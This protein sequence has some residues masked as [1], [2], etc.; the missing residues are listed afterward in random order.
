MSLIEQA[1]VSAIS[2]HANTPII[3]AYSG[4]VDSQ[5]LLHALASLKKNQ[6]LTNPITVCHVNHGL[7]VNAFAWQEFAQQ[8]C[9]RLALPLI[10]KQVNVQAKAQS[11]LEALARDARYQALVEINSTSSLIITGH[12]SDDQ[13]ETF[14]LALKRG[15]GLKG[16]ASMLANSTLGKHKLI[17]PLLGV[18]RQAIVTYAQEQQLSWIEDE[19]NDDTSFDRNF[20]RQEVMPLLSARWGSISQTI[21]R[22]A[23]HCRAGQELLDELGEQ[24]LLHCQLSASVLNVASLQSLSIA[25]FN[26]LIRYFLAK[27][28]CLMP[29]TEQ[30]E[31]VRQ[32]LSADENKN[33]AIKVADHY[34]R[35][36][37]N[38]LH[39]TA[40]LA[41]ISGW[42]QDINIDE[43]NDFTHMIKAAITLPDNLGRL[44]I[45]AG[46]NRGNNVRED[47]T[48]IT[49]TVIIAPTVAQ[50]VSVRFSHNNPICLPDYRRHSRAFKKVLQELNIPP[51]QRKRIPFLYYNDVLVAAIGFF[52]CQEFVPKNS[53]AALYL[54]LEPEVK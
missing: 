17:R 40:E 6:Q 28:Q 50:R 25:R 48:H 35:R 23:E 42:S 10:I 18:S 16:L 39:L 19:S 33:P 3:I 2:S 13:S 20:I 47:D 26:N 52:V 31:Q 51:W 32:Q 4:G 5:V 49:S 22:S 1:L 36:F 54:T 44:S 45:S 27:Q 38:Q 34:L 24:D 21:N 53:Q 7:S 8:Q 37:K 15:A 43:F 46:N 9:S 29:S 12:H 14:L 11:S 41:D 30:L